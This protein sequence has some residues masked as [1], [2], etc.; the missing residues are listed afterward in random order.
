MFLTSLPEFPVLST[1]HAP[2]YARFR[3]LVCVVVLALLTACASSPSSKQ[4]DVPLGPNEYRIQA[5]DTLISIARRHRQSVAS[6]MRM[7]GISNANRISVGQVLKV[8]ADSAAPAAASGRGRGR[9]STTAPA[10]PHA[11][12]P[13]PVGNISLAWPAKGALARRFDGNASKG[14]DIAGSAGAPVLAAAGGDVAYAGDGLR[15]YGNLVIVRHSGNFMTVYAHN[16]KL[17]VKQGQSVK[18]GQKIA[19]MGSRAN[20][21]P[22][23]YFELRAGNRPTDPMRFLSA[24]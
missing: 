10:R 11:A 5:G 3:T 12:D 16:R 8:Q 6:L 17:L 13:A 4:A 2:R 15:G 19:E 18:Q 23:L 9:A 14:I 21:K 24:Q 20:G 7:N 1:S 22:V